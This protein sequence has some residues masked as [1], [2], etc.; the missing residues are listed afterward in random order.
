MLEFPKCKTEKNFFGVTKI[1]Y[2]KKAFINYQAKHMLYLSNTVSSLIF[3]VKKKWN[4]HFEKKALIYIGD[5][6]LISLVGFT[7]FTLLFYNLYCTCCDFKFQVISM[8]NIYLISFFIWD[9]I[10]I[11]HFEKQNM[12]LKHFCAALYERVLLCLCLVI[13]H[14]NKPFYFVLMMVTM[15]E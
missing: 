6:K 8:R 5:F 4:K 2:Q 9:L 14:Y 11:K 1:N 12:K 10:M 15:A 7:L 3:H 13:S